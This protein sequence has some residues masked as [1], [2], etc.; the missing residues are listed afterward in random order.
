MPAD[1]ER[2][3]GRGAKQQRYETTGPTREKPTTGIG[4][5]K[6]DKP[7]YGQREASGGE[8]ATQQM[9]DRI[10]RLREKRRLRVENLT[11][12]SIAAV[13]GT[14]SLPIDALVI[15]PLINTR[16]EADSAKHGCDR[17]NGSCR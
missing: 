5:R 3:R 16:V 8:G 15:G 7:E 13:D 9:V 1:D 4:S 11:V 6:P 17:Q 2:D 10:E 12:K 14:Q